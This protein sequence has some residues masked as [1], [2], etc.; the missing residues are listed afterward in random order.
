MV[1]Q[2]CS[3]VLHAWTRT[4]TD[5][6]WQD[7]LHAGAGAAAG[8]AAGSSACLGGH[9]NPTFGGREVAGAGWGGVFGL[10]V[11]NLV[12]FSILSCKTVFG[13]HLHGACGG[14]VGHT[15]HLATLVCLSAGPV[16]PPAGS[17]DLGHTAPHMPNA[18]LQLQHIIG[19]VWWWWC[20]SELVTRLGAYASWRARALVVFI[21][22]WDHLRGH[23]RKCLE[24]V[25]NAW[26]ESVHPETS[27]LW[28]LCTFQLS[29]VIRIAF[30]GYWVE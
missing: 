4:E 3:R 6:P 15:L 27:L 11:T 10:K 20:A 30:L 28:T 9:L 8:A 26:P 13:S 7:R 2:A 16:F 18:D 14:G 21:G 23:A 5:N 1:L 12:D 19:C 29:P 17:E 24:Q 25:R 22:I